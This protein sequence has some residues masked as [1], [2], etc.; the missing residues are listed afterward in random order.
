MR[1]R[2]VG[3]KRAVATV[4]QSSPIGTAISWFYGDVIPFHGLPID[5]RGTGMPP[6]NKAALRWGMYESAEYRFVRSFLRPD[7]PVVELGS[8]IGAVSST[9]AQ[10]LAP[11]QRLTCLE[12][13][14]A[15]LSTLQRNLCRHAEHL[16]VEV[17]H[18]AITYDA[19]EARFLVAADNLVSHVAASPGQ[20]A[21]VPGTTLTKLCQRLNG[22]PYQLVADIE[23]AE[24]DILDRD[25]SA[26]QCCE[27]MIMELHDSHREDRVFTQTRLKDL[28]QNAGFDIVAEYGAV[29]ACCRSKTWRCPDVQKP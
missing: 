22:S 17:V 15:L 18:A 20:V 19:T 4:L 28:I 24:A 13:N 27:R 10:R 11:G 7:L 8:S 9:I 29:V 5:V 26:L 16:S 21:V 14:P 6:A 12:A 2:L 1:P 3:L 23:G 25:V